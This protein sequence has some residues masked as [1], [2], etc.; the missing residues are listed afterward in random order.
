MGQLCRWLLNGTLLPVLLL[1]A[2]VRASEDDGLDVEPKVRPAPGVVLVPIVPER[3]PNDPPPPA[4]TRH[5]WYGWQ[6]LLADGAALGMFLAASSISSSDPSYF[7]QSNELRSVGFGLSLGTYLLGGPSTHLLHGRPGIAGLDLLARAGLPLVGLGSGILLGGMATH[8]GNDTNLASAVFGA[9]GFVLGVG[10]A[11]VI[12]LTW[13]SHEDRVT[14][15]SASK[16]N[17]GFRWTP[18]LGADPRGG[19]SGG[20]AGVF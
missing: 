20:V 16:D 17:T 3:G 13:L 5:V 19:V 7:S 11:V 10:G 14:E 6:P 8:A 15:E 1:A 18:T 2:P 4:P 9:L 12:D